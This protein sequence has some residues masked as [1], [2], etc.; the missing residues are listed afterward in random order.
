MTI[1]GQAVRTPRTN[2][3]LEFGLVAGRIGRQNIALCLFGGV[4]L[5]SD[6]QGLT[7]IDMCSGEPECRLRQWTS[8]LLAT[9]DQIARTDI[10]HGYS[11]RWDFSLQLNHW[12]GRELQ[13]PS[14]AFVN[15]TL[16]LIIA[17]N[18]QAGRG[19]AQGRVFFKLVTG[20]DTQHTF[21]GDYRTAHEITSADCNSDG[22]LRFTSQAFAVGKMNTTG[23]A[24]AELSGLDLTEP[25]S[26]Q[27]QLHPSGE[28]RA[29]EGTVTT[30]T[31]IGTTGTVKVTKC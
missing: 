29:L 27:W 2:I 10:H 30:G 22:S 19:F 23:A 8:G 25:W 9:T 3:M 31:V 18:G 26:A 28:P 17:A 13:L 16:D 11:G 5:P 7:V 4:E 21:Q 15:G 1:R 12:R 24:P 14:Y 6:L 20:A